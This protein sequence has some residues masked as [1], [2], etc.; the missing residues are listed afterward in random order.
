[1]KDYKMGRTCS[2]H[3]MFVKC[4]QNFSQQMWREETDCKS[5][6]NVK[7]DQGMRVKWQ[8]F[9]NLVMNLQGQSRVFRCQPSAFMQVSDL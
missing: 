2:M 1:M 5:E 9:V 6:H 7:I 3:I 8:A 4:V